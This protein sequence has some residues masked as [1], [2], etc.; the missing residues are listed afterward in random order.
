V[1][2]DS[3]IQVADAD[4][5]SGSLILKIPSIERGAVA[6]EAYATTVRTFT[7]RLL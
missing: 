3:R 1:H 6:D 4:P 2:F 5:S 7:I